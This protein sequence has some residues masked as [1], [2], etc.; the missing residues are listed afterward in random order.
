MPASF[1]AQVA[2]ATEVEA[3]FG[4]E[5]AC[6]GNRGCDA[7]GLVELWRLLSARDC[8]DAA[9]WYARGAEYWARAPATDDG[10][11]GG[12]ARVAPADAR[13]S[14]MF[15]NELL[16]R[17]HAAAGRA[18]DC[19]AGI[20]RVARDVLT[21]RF[22]V[23]D[24]AEQDVALLSRCDGCSILT[25]RPGM[26]AWEL[27]TSPSLL[28]RSLD[29]AAGAVAP[30]IFAQRLCV[31]LQDLSFAGLPHYDA[32]WLQWVLGC[33]TDAD[34]IGLLKR[35]RAALTPSGVIVIKDN[36][37]APTATSCC[38]PPTG[39]P[40]P[41]SPETRASGGCDSGGSP[42]DSD[43]GRGGSTSAAAPGWTRGLFFDY[44]EADDCICRSEAYLLALVAR[45][46]LTV[47]H[48]QLQADWPRDLLP[49]KMFALR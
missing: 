26:A 21:P 43:C 47:V 18:L 14:A 17:G 38:C 42:V 3:A 15:L 7:V 19:G 20:G 23:V 27:P 28:P 2:V 49:V 25:W 9:A 6:I 4:G 22:A 36:V 39:S 48:A 32:I 41:P 29:A 46:G 10:V 31:G 13:E 8:G 37:L 12:L 16:D 40:P 44:D 1:A 34:L 5:S 24:A 30:Q 33:L 45:A 35:A 11:L